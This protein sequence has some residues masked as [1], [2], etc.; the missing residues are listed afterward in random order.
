MTR[1][2]LEDLDL[3][4]IVTLHWLLTEQ[5]V[6]RA[7]A[8]LDVSQPTVS[9][10]LGRLRDL[11]GDPLLIKSGR[12][13]LAT[14]KAEALQPR[15]AEIVD[16]MRD[17]LLEEESFDPANQ[18]GRFRIAVI[19]SVGAVVIRAWQKAVQPD[20]PNLELDILQPAVPQAQDLIAGKIDAIILPEPKMLQLPPGVNVDE[21]VQRP[22]FEE[23]YVTAVRR[24]HPLANGMDIE[25]YV[26]ADH[27]LINPEGLD[28]GAV[29]QVLHAAGMKRRI[30]FRT[31]TFLLA[32][33]V[34]E[35]SDCVLT[36]PATLF[37][38]SRGKF[39]IFDCPVKV[40]SFKLFI[41]WHPNWTH[42]PQHRWVR[43]RLIAEMI[44]MAENCSLS[45]GPRAS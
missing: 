32:L 20:A 8:R 41:G 14:K 34:L 19:D 5:S 1:T 39:S 25:S 21:F 36:A 23:H 30:A 27:I 28:V 9:H 37:N 31:E 13:M 4:L 12:T 33:E 35:N 44:R 6:T 29:D 15:V 26:K 11:L 24:D 45:G 43:E 22:I 16:R 18:S 42:D 10:A 38:F 40:P 7:A 2:R 17:L 3:N